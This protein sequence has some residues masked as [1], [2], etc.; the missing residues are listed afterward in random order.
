MAGRK[1]GAKKRKRSKA[2]GS[3]SE[4]SAAAASASSAT[5]AEQIIDPTHAETLLHGIEKLWRNGEF[6]DLEI[7][8]HADP[9]APGSAAG[10]EPVRVKVHAVVAAAMSRPFAQMLTG[11]MESVKDGVL[12][13]RAGIAGCGVEPS[14]LGSVA[15]FFYTGKLEVTEDTAWALLK[16]LNYLE[17]V[18]AKALCVE[19]L[20]NKLSAENAMGAARAADEFASPELKNIAEQYIERDFESVGLEGEEVLRLSEEELRG[21]LQRDGLHVPTELT[22]FPDP[23]AIGAPSTARTTGLQWRKFPD[24]RAIGAPSTARTTGL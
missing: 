19:F 2:A 21:W 17:M 16:T 1:T 5:T 18:P 8:A 7:E 3:D 9:A 10:S 23:R 13:L 6:L 24:P 22:V 11:K 12:T 20:C 4:S 15:E 14:V